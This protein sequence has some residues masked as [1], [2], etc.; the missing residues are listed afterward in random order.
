VLGGISAAFTPTDL[1]AL[2]ITAAEAV[3]G[4]PSDLSRRQRELAARA[5]VLLRDALDDD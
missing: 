5:Y 4:E 1:D 3:H 2:V